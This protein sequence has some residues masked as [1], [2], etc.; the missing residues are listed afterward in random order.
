LGPVAGSPF[1][2]RCY[3]V[4]TSA[5][6]PRLAPEGPALRLLSVLVPVYNEEETVGVLLDR[7]LSVTLPDSMDREI[8]VVDDGSTDGSVDAVRAAMARHPAKVRLFIQ[9]QNRGKGAA[10]RAAIAQAAGE[11]A[12]IQDADLE[13]DPN[14]YPRLM[15]PLLDGRADAVYGS[16]FLVSGERRVLYYWHSLANHALTTLCN[17]IADV[18]LTD[19]ET[20]YK[21]FRLSLVKSIP[22]RSERFGIEP[23]LTIK[24]AQRHACIYELPVSYHGRTYGEGK[25]IGLKDALQAFFVILRYG[26]TR[27]IYLDSGAKILDALAQTPRFNEWMASCVRPYLGPTVLELGAGIGNLTQ[28][29]ARGRKRYIATDVDEEHLSR[30]RTRFGARPNVELRRCDLESAGDFKPLRESVATVVC[31]NVLEHVADDMQGLRNI[32]SALEPGGVAVLLVPADPRIYGTLDTVLGHHRR[33]TEGEIRTKLEAAGFTVE[34]VF[35]FNRITR[36]GWILN[37]RILRRDSFGRV[38]LWIFDRFVWLWRRLERILP[39]DPV[40]LIVAA[41]KPSRE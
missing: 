4:A 28:C 23:E 37:G 31:L 36:P 11:F 20:C 7:V 3:N 9:E 19:M 12:I 6:H 15:Q 2:G 41:R 40:S 10:I 18:N 35:G 38:Q 13:Y 30:L 8:I 21:A 25:K 14:D 24:L 17:M 16:R 27:D 33:Y 32:R 22:L 26:A 39:W 29:L 34:R 5:L 1:I